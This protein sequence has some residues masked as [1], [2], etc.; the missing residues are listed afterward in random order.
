M[1][2]FVFSNLDL[3]VSAIRRELGLRRFKY[4][5]MAVDSGTDEAAARRTY[6]IAVI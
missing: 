1:K 2:V 6:R 3:A 5:S 4:V